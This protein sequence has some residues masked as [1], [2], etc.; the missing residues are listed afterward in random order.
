MVHTNVIGTSPNSI[1]THLEI[2]PLNAINNEIQPDPS[3]D[4]AKLVLINRYKST[5]KPALA[6]VRGL[7]LQ[8]IAIASSVSHDSHNI[9]AAGCSDTLICN[10]VNKVIEEKGGI[11]I[12]TEDQVKIIKLPIAGLISDLTI[13]ELSSLQ[14]EISRLLIKMNNRLEAPFMTLS[15]LSLLVIP[16]VKISNRGLFLVMENQFINV[17]V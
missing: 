14:N 15:F 4:I 2:F 10:A 1:L 3:K 13:E 17:E 6:F 16:N 5:A 11:C 8:Q 12:A 9:I 7:N